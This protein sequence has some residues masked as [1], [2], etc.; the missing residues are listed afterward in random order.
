MEPGNLFWKLGHKYTGHKLSGS[1]NLGLRRFK[2]FYGVSPK[3]CEIIWNKLSDSIPIHS[4][5]IHLLWCLH[6]LKHYNTEHNN[7]AIFRA[8]EKSI[9]KWVWCLIELLSDMEVV[10]KNI[11]I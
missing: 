11:Y 2:G 8:D 7:S 5:P 1:V 6:F 4:Q 3:I 9:R 10:S